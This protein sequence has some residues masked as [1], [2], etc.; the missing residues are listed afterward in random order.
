MRLSTA[1]SQAIV[2]EALPIG[3]KRMWK[4]GEMVKLGPGKWVRATAAGMKRAKKREGQEKF[5]ST[6]GKFK[7][8]LAAGKYA[9]G[10]TFKDHV[11]E[12]K[13]ER[14]QAISRLDGLLGDLKSM[15]PSTAEVTG[16]PKEL[17]S[18]L[19]KVTR[20][21]EAAEKE[22]QKTGRKIESKVKRPSDLGDVT[23]TRIIADTIGEVRDTVKKIKGR[24]KVTEEEDAI[25]N[26]KGAYRSI[27]LSIVDDDGKEK[28]VQVRTR[29]QHT[30]AEWAHDVYKP[31]T[32]EQEKTAEKHFDEIEGY[33]KGM[34]DFFYAQ[35]MGKNPP[36]PPRPD[37][38]KGIVNVFGCL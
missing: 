22:S 9:P 20:K 30:F 11:R 33:S 27:H 8:D 32:P 31:L 24:F 12:G 38:P 37:C 10:M 34:S 19:G 2:E 21:V 29:N 5:R 14:A 25:T 16:R 35:D 6:I 26:P 36:P 13:A 4:R 23:G 3:T 7:D 1:L 15:A 17:E 28:E 18:I